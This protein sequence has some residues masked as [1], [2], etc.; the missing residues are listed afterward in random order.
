MK[1]LVL[2]TDGRAHALVWKLFNSNQISEVYCAPG[3]GGTQQLAYQLDLDLQNAAEIAHWSFQEGVGLVV[4]ASD[5][6]LQA[7]LVDE[8][9]VGVCGPPQR[10]LRIA[11]SRC[12]AK[13]F[14]LRHQLPTAPGR[15]FTDKVTAERYL[16][17]QSFPVVVKADNRAIPSQIHHDRYAALRAIEEIFET[18]P[19]EGPND[20]VV[21]ETYL[22][23]YRISISAITDGKTVL[24]FLPTRVYDRLND[25]DRG[26][27][28]P[29]MGAHTSTST[30]ATKLTHYLKQHIL[31]PLV[32]A[33]AKEQLPYRGILGVDCIVTDKGPR[34]HAIRCEM[35]DQEAQ[36]VLPRLESDL[37]PLLSAA[38]EGK[39]E[40]IPPPTWKDEVSVGIALVTEG[41]P[42][43]FPADNPIE[44]LTN[45]DP[46]ILVFH[47]Q[48]Y[49]PFG[50]RYQSVTTRSVIDAVTSHQPAIFTTTGGHVLTIV[51]T[52][53]TLNGARG[54]AILNAE[55]ITFAGRYFRSDIGQKEFV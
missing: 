27:L 36:V 49:S 13:E 51:A 12:F 43:N 29:G 39:L 40:S 26:P 18:H 30:Y 4:P 46:G 22:P 16:V 19:A 7:G 2:G 53:A 45:L 8:S 44:G 52:A 31:E 15:A 24:P 54:K 21:I 9:L 37:M 14:L 23:G 28:A 25:G 55:R 35:R 17:T 32:V 20:G 34:I 10:T 42:H 47:D 3:N 48:T 5:V 1:V 33:L 11:R 38:L 6:P 50:M 41:Y